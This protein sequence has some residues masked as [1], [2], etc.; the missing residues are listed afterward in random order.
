MN[1]TGLEL[2]LNQPDLHVHLLDLLLRAVKCLQRLVEPLLPLAQLLLLISSG[3]P[4]AQ[5]LVVLLNKLGMGAT[6]S[7]L[8][9]LFIFQYSTA[10]RPASVKGHLA[11]ASR[12]LVFIPSARR[13]T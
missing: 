1:C 13:H 12:V 11:P 10:G 6:A 3:M 2:L 7:E 8:S 9:F 5:I 4:S